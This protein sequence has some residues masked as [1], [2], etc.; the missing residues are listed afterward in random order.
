MD[1]TEQ[2]LKILFNLIEYRVERNQKNKI[3]AYDYIVLLEKLSDELHR[4]IGIKKN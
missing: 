1:L 3:S 4:V 2:E